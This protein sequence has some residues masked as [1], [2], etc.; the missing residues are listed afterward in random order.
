MTLAGRR[1]GLDT[2]CGDQQLVER[3]MRHTVAI[4]NVEQRPLLVGD[5]H[6]I[7]IV[8]GKAFL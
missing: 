8:I 5:A 4:D 2:A 7:E 3:M 1:I 6:L